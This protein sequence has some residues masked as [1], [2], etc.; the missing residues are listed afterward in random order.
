MTELPVI[1]FP[2]LETARLLLRQ[3]R[4][5][6]APEVLF[7]R[8]DERVMRYIQRPPAQTIGEALEWIRRINQSVATGESCLWGLSLKP[9]ERIIGTITLWNI[10]KEHYR[11]EIGYVLHPD[12]WGKRIM[13]E[14]LTAVADFGFTNLNLHSIEG[15][16]DPH[17]AASIRLMERNGFV[18]EAYF[19]E[20]FF[21]EGRFLDTAVYSLLR[22]A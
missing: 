14:A 19:R 13:Q 20:N 18:R 7:L 21:F 16:V 15:Q 4:D 17:N 10:E 1:P 22:P 8:S 6:D 3:L 9:D 12:Y 11:A 5:S 2:E